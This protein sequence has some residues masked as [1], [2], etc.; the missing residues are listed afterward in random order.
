ME[1]IE[2]IEKEV[3]E[4]YEKIIR[5]VKMMQKNYEVVENKEGNTEL[6][7]SQKKEYVIKSGGEYLREV[8]KRL[9]DLSLRVKET[10]EGVEDT[11]V[12]TASSSL[13]KKTY[14]QCLL[15]DIKANL[16]KLEE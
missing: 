11:L 6:N 9:G 4:N 2:D 7:A 16:K 5:V 15:S 12:V 10:I 13:N 1:V 8:Y 3:I 14:E